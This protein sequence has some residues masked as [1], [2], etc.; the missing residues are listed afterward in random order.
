VHEKLVKNEYDVFWGFF[1]IIYFQET[2][3]QSDFQKGPELN[4]QIY[5][6]DIYIYI[7]HNYVNIKKLYEGKLCNRSL[8]MFSTYIRYF[9]KPVDQCELD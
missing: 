3:S 7:L 6:E 2:F 8:V 5:K 1:I 9:C 4:K